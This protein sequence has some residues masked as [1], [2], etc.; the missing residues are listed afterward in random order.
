MRPAALLTAGLFLTLLASPL[1]AAG[2]APSPF[3]VLSVPPAPPHSH[4]WAYLAMLGGAALVG[5]SFYFHSQ[6]DEAYSDYLASTDPAEI[7]RLYDDANRFDTLS[8]ASLTTGEI[9]IATGLY[10]RFVRRP[11][12]SRTAVIVSGTRCAIAVNF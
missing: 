1:Q 5:T 12:A 4:K 8:R 3:P 10:F 2:E 11:A 9:L 7:E 6:A